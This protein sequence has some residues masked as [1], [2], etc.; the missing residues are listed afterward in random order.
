MVRKFGRAVLLFALCLQLSGC[1]PA[2]FVVGGAAGAGAVVWV[3]GKLEEELK[4]PLGKVHQASLAALKELELPVQE[5]K[6]DMLAAEIRSEFADGKDIWISIRSLTESSTKI[7]IR[8]GMFGDR[9]RSQRIL[10][11]VHRHL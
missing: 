3:K 9:A 10:D 6:K 4:L 11:T 1:A 2:V 7:T 8:V 5:D